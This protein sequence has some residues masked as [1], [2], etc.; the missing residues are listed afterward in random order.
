LGAGQHT[1]VTSTCWYEE[2]NALDR[3]T[4]SDGSYATTSL[5][6]VNGGSLYLEKSGFA[7]GAT[8]DSVGGTL[9]LTNARFFVGAPAITPETTTSTSTGWGPTG[10]FNLNG[11]TCTVV[12]NVPS[13]NTGNLQI[14]VDNSTT[15][16]ATSPLGG[17]TTS[18]VV[19]SGVMAAGN[20]TFTFG[21]LTTNGTD[22]LQIRADSA[23]NV[24]ISSIRMDCI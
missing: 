22:F 24:V 6:P 9:T 8:F 2:F 15:A 1:K 10:V 12:I 4:F 11:K 21:P 19:Q 7:A 20:N 5:S 13:A 18:R 3:T 14:F 23:T 16:A 17:T